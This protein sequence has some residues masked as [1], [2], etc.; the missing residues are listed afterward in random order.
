MPRP[1]L[2]RDVERRKH[3]RTWITDI[4][5]SKQAKDTLRQSEERWQL[6]LRATGDDIF[7]WNLVTGEEFASARI[8]EI[9]GY[10]EG[11]LTSNC[12]TWSS[13][14]HPE[15]LDGILVAV[16]AHL[17]GKAPLYQAEYRLRCKDGSYKWILARGQAQWDKNGKPVRLV[18][19]KQDI[20]DRKQAEEEIQLLLTIS[21]AI[22]TAPDFDTALVVALE[23]MCETTNW[24]YG[25][26]WIP[27]T[28]ETLACSP[29]WYCQRQQLEPSAMRAIEHFREYSE[30]LNFYPGEE[31]PGQV[32]STRKSQVIADLSEI[33]DL[34]DRLK[35]VTDCGLKAGFGIPIIGV[36]N[37]DEETEEQNSCL[38]SSHSPVLAVLV[39]FTRST[40]PEDR[41]LIQLVNVVAEQL[42]TV[43]QQKKGQAEMKALFAAMTDRI[44]VRDVSGRCLNVIA[45]N[46]KNLCTPLATT[47]GSK[48]HQELPPQQADLILDGILKA[49]STQ[50][51]VS[52]EYCIQS[53][54]QEVWL[55]ETISP[56][57]QE[58]AILVARD[59]SDRKQAE[60]AL[61]LEKQKSEQL[62]LNILPAPIAYQLK[63]HQQAIAEQFNQVTIMF[64]DI[65]GFTPLSARL[66]PIELLN[67]LNRIFSAFD[68]LVEDLG[69][70]KIKTIGDAYMVAAGLPIP[71]ADHAEAIAQ[72]ALAMQAAIK[73]FQAELKENIQIRIGINTGAAVAGVIGTKKFSYDLW[74]DA[75]NIASR[76]ESCGEAGRIQVTATTYEIL[77]DKYLF[78][79]RGNIQVRGRGEMETYWL[80][81]CQ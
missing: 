33:P 2:K 21:E 59:I 12:E 42:G 8:L 39:F 40:R 41:R 52:I 17:E 46:T 78:E 31:I 19:V 80:V 73:R 11:E 76:M 5:A 26:I 3:K 54:S 1:I 27:R 15:D 16:Q 37:R 67:L 70:E 64:A 60:T 79:R 10:A 74:G 62:L 77:K 68:E 44:V 66:K 69:L 49:V 34:L 51:T 71:R 23:K 58:T 28:D 43:L 6:A 81:G 35:M 38:L 22:N 7:D 72:M 30:L 4:T 13:L 48:L 53:G 47:I 65:V 57:S 32:W 63:H 9:L 36:G 45:T 75:V 55:A 18:G 29:R 14:V 61:R 24:I 25:E 56:L 50:K 20:S